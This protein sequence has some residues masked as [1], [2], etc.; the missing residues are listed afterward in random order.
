MAATEKP[1]TTIIIR[2]SIHPG[3][4][5]WMAFSTAT[6]VNNGRTSDSVAE[7]EQ[8]ARDWCKKKQMGDIKEVV[9]VSKI[10]GE[11]DL[12]LPSEN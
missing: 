4:V 2:P 7:A 5:C 8:A 10:H 6:W 9:V 12:G 11:P 1:T 3:K